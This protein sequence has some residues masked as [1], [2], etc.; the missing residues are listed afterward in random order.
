MESG[1]NAGHIYSVM[2]YMWMFSTS[3]DDAHVSLKN[4][5]SSRIS[6]NGSQQTMSLL[7]QERYIDF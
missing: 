4:F 2:T 7:Y 5:P 1:I 6:V 3:L